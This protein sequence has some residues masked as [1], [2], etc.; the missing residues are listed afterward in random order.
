MPL[1]KQNKQMLLLYKSAIDFWKLPLEIGANHTKCD[2]L[3]TLFYIFHILI[4]E[5]KRVFI[6]MILIQVLR[7]FE[8]KINLNHGR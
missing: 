3:N 6:S 8:F 5:I 1:F 7:Y 4:M 2:S